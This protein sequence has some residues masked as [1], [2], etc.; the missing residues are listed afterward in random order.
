MSD[1][2]GATKFW[3][4]LTGLKGTE[5]GDVDVEIILELLIRV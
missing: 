2:S 5:R 4:L 1:A 3:G